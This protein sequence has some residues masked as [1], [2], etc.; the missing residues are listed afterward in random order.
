MVN[1]H[2]GNKIFAQHN[3]I[4]IH[5]FYGLHKKKD[6][7]PRGTTIYGLDHTT[8]YATHTGQSSSA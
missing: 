2:K 4:S 8:Q 3:A 5:L 6:G 7:C 1:L